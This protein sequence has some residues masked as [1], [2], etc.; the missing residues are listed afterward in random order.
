MTVPGGEKS[1]ATQTQRWQQD[2][3]RHAP[4]FYEYLKLTSCS[5]RRVKCTTWWEEKSEREGTVAGGRVPSD[6][7]RLY[8][9]GLIS[10]KANF[11]MDR[12]RTDSKSPQCSSNTHRHKR[13]VLSNHCFRVHVVRWTKLRK[14]VS[15]RA[16]SHKDHLKQ[17]SK[18]SGELASVTFLMSCKFVQH[19]SPY[20][21]DY[22]PFPLRGTL[23]CR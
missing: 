21:S 4:L 15:L 7:L 9:T 18:Q 1:N 10:V 16:V 11:G 13:N 3:W 6:K 20:N 12:V 22:Q 23:N 17:C 2:S 19:Q 5:S 8:R 14:N